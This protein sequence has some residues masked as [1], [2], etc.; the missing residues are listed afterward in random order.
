MYIFVHQKSNDLYSMAKTKLKTANRATSVSRDTV[1]S[2]IATSAK[3]G[4]YTIKTSAGSALN[5][6]AKKKK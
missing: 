2:V 1:K 4:T 3:T 6:A 5:Q